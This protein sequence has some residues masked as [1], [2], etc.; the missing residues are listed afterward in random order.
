[1]SEESVSSKYDTMPPGRGRRAHDTVVHAFRDAVARAPERVALRCGD[2][3]LTYRE[4]GRCVEALAIRLRT[5]GAAGGR[6]AIVLPNSP[7]YAV[8]VLAALASGAQAA[9][10][11][12]GYPAA[13]LRPLL[14]DADPTLLVTGAAAGRTARELGRELGIDV[15]DFA[16][17]GLDL[18]TW[19]QTEPPPGDHRLAP[20]PDDLA[21]LMYTGGTTGIPK[22]VDHTHRNLLLTVQAMEACWPTEPDTETWLNVAPM[23]HI[24]GLLMGLL[25]P[26][27]G[28]AELVMAA[29]RFD[30]AALARALVEHRVTV[31]GGGPAAIYAGLLAA[32]L[33]A[34]QLASLRV[35]PGGG[36][37]FPRELLARWQAATGVPVREAFGMTELAPIACNPS[38]RPPRPGSV[39]LPAPLVEIAVVAGAGGREPLP[40]GQ[41]G[42]IVARAPHMLIRYRNRPAETADALADGLLHTG[43]LGY[44]DDDGYLYIVDRKKDMILVGGF[45]VFP[46]EIDEILA[47]HPSVLR[48]VTLGFAD[49]RKGERP[50]SFVVATPDS[51]L[52]VDELHRWCAA[53][54]VAYKRPAD[55]REV[56]DIPHTAANKVDRVALRRRHAESIEPR[57][58]MTGPD[59]T[60]T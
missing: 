7:E 46:R 9:L 33:D 55:I 37:P 49:E 47:A 17:D 42:E 20:H 30:P 1:M 19:R 39:G 45:N 52:D 25:N 14:A 56:G 41:V 28:R 23:F 10:F 27:Y 60:R 2:R 40:P 18:D 35:C 15:L 12:P 57:P 43:D 34:G 48:A 51:T 26:M 29:P 21:T 16:P 38:S 54:L 32:E 4:Y 13:E 50:V 36:A 58:R 53:R 22:G 24:W 11:N 5:A 8:A 6:V 44:L 3:T 31:F 59:E